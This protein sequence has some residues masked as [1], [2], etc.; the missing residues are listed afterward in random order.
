MS[1]GSIAFNVGTDKVPFSDNEILGM[2]ENLDRFYR[3]LLYIYF[4][5]MKIVFTSIKYL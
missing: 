2:G 4:T 1:L 3:R 5:N